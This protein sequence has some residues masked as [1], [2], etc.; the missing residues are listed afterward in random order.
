MQT[1]G[2]VITAGLIIA[3]LLVVP[4]KLAKVWIW[5]IIRPIVV[6]LFGGGGDAVMSRSDDAPLVDRVSSQ[7]GRTDAPPAA[8]TVDRAALR[9]LYTILRAH[10][11]QREEIRAALKGVGVPLS[12]DLW[13]DAAPP[14]PTMPAEPDHT[15]PIAARPTRANFAEID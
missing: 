2:D 1:L 11:I 9:T 4:Y 6:S 13:R 5:P 10:D 8:R 12:N 3:A 15:T 7:D 14:P